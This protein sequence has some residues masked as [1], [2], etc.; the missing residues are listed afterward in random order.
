MNV[1]M[2]NILERFRILFRPVCKYGYSILC[3]EET[4]EFDIYNSSNC[5]FLPLI[6]SITGDRIFKKTYKKLQLNCFENQNKVCY[7]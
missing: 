3:K 7:I 4:M 6:G 1:G 5:I 2:Y